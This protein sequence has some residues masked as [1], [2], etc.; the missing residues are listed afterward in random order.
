MEYPHVNYKKNIDSNII[1]EQLAS[2]YSG[3]E[4]SMLLNK[5]N[6]ES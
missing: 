3:V 4:G 2:N 1:I 5:D 6:T